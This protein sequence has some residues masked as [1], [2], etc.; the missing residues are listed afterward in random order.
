MALPPAFGLRAIRSL[1]NTYT[2]WDT[3]VEEVEGK[4]QWALSV[5]IYHD[6]S[7]GHRIEL[8]HGRTPVAPLVRPLGRWK[9]LGVPE[10]VLNDAVASVDA[11]LTE[12]LVT[13]YGVQGTFEEKW[14][15][16]PDPF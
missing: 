7:F 1:P 8:W 10:S 13:R 12:H 15:H 9:G 16:E 3:L 6:P 4:L 14:G 11:C 5:G 2:R